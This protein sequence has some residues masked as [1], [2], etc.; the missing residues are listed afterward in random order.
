VFSRAVVWLR[1]PFRRR[2]GAL[3]LFLLA[4]VIGVGGWLTGRHIWAEYH[5][6][7][8]RR[9]LERYRLPEAQQHLDQCLQVWPS[10]FEVRLLAAQT[11]RRLGDLEAAERHLACC[12][13]IRGAL[14]PEV[15]MEQT[16][17]RAQRGGMDSV[18]PYLRSLVEQNDPATPLILEAMVKGYMRAFRYGD[19]SFLLNVWLDRWP[20][21]IEAHLFQANVCEQ[22]GPEQ[23]AVNHYRKVLE[24]DPEQEEARLRLAILLIHRAVPAEALEHLERLAEKRPGDPYILSKRAHCLLALG[25]P[26]EAE[27]TADRILAE[28]SRYRP[29]VS[30]KGAA[31][32]ALNRPA[33]AEH[34]LRQALAMDASDYQVQHWLAR[35]LWEQGKDEEAR[36]AEDRLRVLTADGQRIREIIQVD[37][38]KSPN[39]PALRTE[40]GNIFLRA[41]SEREGVQW[42]YSALRQDPKYIPAH[43]ALAAYF[44][45]IGEPARAAPHKRFL[46][47]GLEPERPPSSESAP[48]DN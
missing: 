45:R 14:S 27:E 2:R 24:L 7:A 20:D 48:T 11:A 34:W 43:R 38:N 30:I 35:S 10:S 47:G 5:Y 3:A 32:L 28:D 26:Q 40:I 8:A 15:G 39:D 13:E 46:E 37:I 16:L 6:R 41:G 42:L 4:L 17:I 36:S 22:I 44:E 19:A 25:R 29:A 1:V 21:D 12:Q 31:A 23:E 18:T 9:A 33:E